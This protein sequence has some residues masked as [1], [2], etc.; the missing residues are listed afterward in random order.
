MI[1]VEE[2]GKI[3]RGYLDQTYPLLDLVIVETIEFPIGWVVVYQSRRFV[4]TGDLDDMMV[5]PGPILILKAD[6]RIVAL[7]SWGSPR[8]MV[9]DYI[10]GG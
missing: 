5:G 2:A 10:D 7:G 4:E 8:E 1:G 3:A 9:R 6:A